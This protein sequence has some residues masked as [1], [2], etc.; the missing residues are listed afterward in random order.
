MRKLPAVVN[1]EV[2]FFVLFVFLFGAS[3]GVS[4][5]WKHLMD[6]CCKDTVGKDSLAFMGWVMAIIL[7]VWT[8][9]ELFAKIERVK[10]LSKLLVAFFN[11]VDVLFQG[12]NDYEYAKNATLPVVV[13]GY[14]RYLEYYTAL[15]EVLL[16]ILTSAGLL[17]LEAGAS[18]NRITHTEAVDFIQG[19]YASALSSNRNGGST[20]TTNISP[21]VSH[22]KSIFETQASLQIKGEASYSLL[23]LSIV[24]ER[25]QFM[26]TKCEN[27]QFTECAPMVLN[28]T[29]I[30]GCIIDLKVQ[31]Q[32]FLEEPVDVAALPW[33][34]W[35]MN[36]IGLLFPFLI[37]PLF[38]STMGSNIF[39]LGPVLFFFMGGVVLFDICIGNHLR[40]P[41]TL[42]MGPLYLKFNQ[43]G[44]KMQYLFTK[45][46]QHAAAGPHQKPVSQLIEAL[47]S[48]QQ[49]DNDALR[50]QL[51]A[52]TKSTMQQQSEQAQLSLLG[53]TFLRNAALSAV[54]TSGY[55]GVDNKQI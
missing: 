37:P 25:I 16:S 12:S 55:L 47:N 40:H 11:V 36:I 3:W 23:M 39:Y 30:V 34:K 5:G 21:E 17:F 43:L 13:A 52:F 8:F 33:I 10:K 14:P 31:M 4:Y 19:I 45:R 49:L 44:D 7:F 46:F 27:K 28:Y 18:D 48:G 42:Y 22:L 51:V 6:G 15:G 9:L 1:F 2:R 50:Q 20:T 26:Q 32:T 54:S 38:Y 41:T 35:P 29:L 24:A 53:S